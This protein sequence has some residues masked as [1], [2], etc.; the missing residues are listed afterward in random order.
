VLLQILPEPWFPERQSQ[1][2]TSELKSNVKSMTNGEGRYTAPLLKPTQYRVVASGN[3]LTSNKADASVLVGREEVV[4]LKMIPTGEQQTVTVSADSGQLIDAESSALV[5]TLTG[6]QVQ[7]LPAPG[8][9][10]TTVAFTAPG[11]VLNAG[12]SYGN[13]SSDGLPGTSNLYVLNG[14]DD[15]DPFLNLNNSGS[16]NLSLGQGEISEAAVVQSGY[17]AQYG[18]AAGVIINW[19][20]KS[21]ANQIHGAANYFYNGDT[22]NANDWFRNNVGEPREKAVSNQWAVNIGGPI[23]KGKLFYF[24]DNEGLYYVLP[25]S[26]PATFP[27][28]AFE[29]TVL[30]RIRSADT[31]LY[32]QAFGLYNSSPSIKSAQPITASQD[33]TGTLG[34]GSAAALGIPDGN[35]GTFGTTSPCALYGFGTGSNQNK[36]WLLTGRVDWNI[37]D[38]H[39]LFG[40]YK[41]DRGSQPTYTSFIIPVFNTVSSQPVYEG[42]LNDTYL[43]NQN[44]TNQFVFAANW[45]TAYFGP[46]NLSTTLAAFPT[47]LN[48]SFGGLNG[49]TGV[50]TLGLPYFF[51]QGR[52][53]TQFQFV[54]DLSWVKGKHTF[55]FGYNFRRN[56]ISDYDAQ[57]NVQGNYFLSL[58]DFANGTISNANGSTFTQNYATSGTAHLALYNLGAYLQDEWQTAPRLKLTLGLRFDRT[59]DPLCNNNC[60]SLYNGSFPYG[61]VSTSTPYNREIR[62]DQSHSFANVQSVLVQ[63]RVGFSYDVT[64]SGHT[65]V[66]GG[67]GLFSDLYPAGFLDGFIQNFPNLYAATITSGNVAK[68]SVGG[69]APAIV[70]ASYNSLISGFAT[71]QS[72]SQIA[73]SVPGFPAPSFAIAPNKIKEP[74]YAEWNLQV[75]H[76]ISRTDA[77]IIGYVGNSGYDEFIANPWL[78]AYSATP[79]GGLPT[80]PAD[81]SLQNVHEYYNG[82]HSNYNGGSV[83]YKHIDNKGVSADVTYTYSKALD[84]VSDGG[85]GEYYNPGS[86]TTQLTP[87]GPGNLNYSYADYDVRHSLAADYVWELPFRFH[88][89]AENRALSGWTVAGKTFWR[90]G[91]PF[92]VY[93]NSIPNSIN[94]TF[95]TGASGANEVIADVAA[96][97]VVGR[98]CGASAGNPATPCFSATDFVSSGQFDFGNNRRK[99]FFGPHYA[100]TDLRLSKK[101]VTTERF[102]VKLGASAFNVFN[103][104]NFSL[105]GGNVQS[106][107]GAITSIAAPPTSPYGSF[108]NAGVGGRV[109]QV[110]GKITF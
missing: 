90:G 16:S 13:F 23:S 25:A 102:D 109:M 36:E 6:T 9:D 97:G 42:Q 26:G 7:E 41:M 105:P 78:N 80:T 27:T 59:G 21:G 45:Y 74:T 58:S 31:P 72:S 88:N 60:F 57:Q 22:L 110:F 107:P 28:Q 63:P 19:T 81:P 39:K 46:S 53:V 14:F 79:F 70:E 10:I 68:P 84:D 11:V 106:D 65:V 77:I 55:R 56:D 34:C 87:A 47:Y 43:I 12:G 15:E 92:S 29:N 66:R 101:F 62:D 75:Q 8:G 17:S 51:P 67:F 93:N 52:N 5:T 64:G 98:H 35:G 61:N 44:V 49:S 2:Q 86:V 1:S 108:Q 91:Q 94:G 76:Q 95:T 54:D 71:G 50:G 69:S 37:S 20:T 4:H 73:A 103:H 3:G 82:A 30:A 99:S 24:V 96:P 83:T 89:F 18:R 48:F 85:T 33:P 32:Q 104:P 40:R 100:D 38:K